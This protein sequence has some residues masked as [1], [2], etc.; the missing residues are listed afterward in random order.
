MR[1]IHTWKR[2][3][4]IL[5]ALVFCATLLCG[6]AAEME[7]VQDLPLSADM[8][9]KAMNDQEQMTSFA[10]E[11]YFQSE[12]GRALQPERR[13]ITHRRSQSRVYAAIEA[14]CQGPTK[15]NL[16]A[17]MPATLWLKDVLVSNGICIVSFEGDL[18]YRD[19]RMFLTLRAAVAAT[20][21][22]ADSN[23]KYVDIMINGRQPGYGSR[24]LGLLKPIETSLEAYIANVEQEYAAG[25]MIDQ[26]D[27]PGVFETREAALYFAA[28]AGH[29]L[30]ADT[31]TLYYGRDTTLEVILETLVEEL[32]KGPLGGDTC[33]P[34]L[35]AD[36]M[37]EGAYF[38]ASVPIV[39]QQESKKETTA[40]LPPIGGESWIQMQP[41]KD[42]AQLHLSIANSDFDPYFVSGALTLTVMNCIP[43]IQGVRIIINGNAMT[44]GLN[45]GRD[46]YVFSDFQ[47]LLGRN[48]ELIYP[49]SNGAGLTQIDHCLPQEGVGDPTTYLSALLDDE[50]NVEMG[51][52]GFSPDD[53]LEVYIAGDIAVVN[54]KAGFLEKLRAYI[55][56]SADADFRESLFVFSIVNTLTQ[57][58]DVTS[59][60]ML[61][62]GHEIRQSARNIYLGGA[63]WRNP[64]LIVE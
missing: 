46:Y 42:V 29:L 53:V 13:T 54:W 10:A 32:M 9:P 41:G 59:V 47:H 52:E 25:Y 51:F 11:L 18:L 33:E 49:L 16:Y 57:L 63:L 60:W 34:V 43:T 31:R 20:A 5:L 14:L 24:P 45:S 12:G 26:S 48:V 38:G 39:I 61:E 6:C 58:P 1:R 3:I 62:N 27:N 15:E 4:A 7:I 56:Q 36:M 40:P 55:G 22:A 23:I 37:L 35:P 21:T 19:A 8:A 17:V 28:P 50:S 64:G 44:D 2:P 30:L